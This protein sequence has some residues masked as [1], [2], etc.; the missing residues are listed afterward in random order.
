MVTKVEAP[1]E[2]PDP[3]FDALQAM[4]EQLESAGAQVNQ[5]AEQKQLVQEVNSQAEGAAELI[6]FVWQIGGPFVPARY[7]VCYDEER[8]RKI[9]ETFAALAVKRGWEF[10]ELMGKFG[11]EL[12]FMGAIVGPALPV[13]MLEMKARKEAAELMAGGAHVG[14]E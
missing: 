1:A 5:A 7:A 12:A 10:G 14:A 2:A 8:R 6:E 9:G 4:A 3:G 11:A 13:V